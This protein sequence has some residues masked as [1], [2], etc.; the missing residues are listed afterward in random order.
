[1]ESWQDYT[2]QCMTS[3]HQ[4]TQEKAYPD[5]KEILKTIYELQTFAEAFNRPQWTEAIERE[6]NTLIKRET[7]SN[8]PINPEIVPLPFK[9]TFKAS[10][11]DCTGNQH[12]AKE[13]RYLRRDCQLA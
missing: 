1:M 7:W 12:M 5:G 8:V 4:E 13:R 9:W 6:Y 11:L 2:I 3:V 10:T